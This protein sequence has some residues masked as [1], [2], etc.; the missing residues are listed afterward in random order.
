MKPA[1]FFSAAERGR[2]KPLLHLRALLPFGS[3]PE[4]IDQPH[5]QPATDFNVFGRQQTTT[6]S[7]VH[8]IH[9]SASQVSHALS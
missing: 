3:H 9:H 8:A 6:L 7:A 4:R 2:N 5:S 1:N